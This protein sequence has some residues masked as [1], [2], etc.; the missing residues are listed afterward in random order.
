MPPTT[1]DI[2]EKTAFY[3][4]RITLKS[5]PRSDRIG[6]D[7]PLN[8]LRNDII[9]PYE[10]GEKF[11]LE[12]ETIDPY[13]IQVIKVNATL[14][15]STSLL[16]AIKAKRTK[17]NVISLISDEWRVTEE[18]KD[19]TRDLITSLPGST[20]NTEKKQFP[21]ATTERGSWISVNPVFAGRGFP[22]NDKLCFVLI[23]LNDPFTS[24]FEHNIKPVA[25]KCGLTAIKADDILSNQPIM[26]DV[27]ALL[28]QARLVIA[29]LSYS[30]PNVFYELGIA[31][32]LGKEVIM[33]AQD[34]TEA[35]FDVQHIRY[36][37]YQYPSK[38]KE[39]ESELEGTIKQVLKNPS[40]QIRIETTRVGGTQE[41]KKAI[42]NPRLER[43]ATLTTWGRE[44]AE[45]NHTK[46]IEGDDKAG[47]YSRASGEWE[48]FERITSAIR[49]EAVKRWSLA[50]TTAKDYADTVMLTLEPEFRSKVHQLVE[51][52]DARIAAENKA[53]RLRRN[54]A[55]EA[56]EQ[57]SKSRKYAVD[58]TSFLKALMATGQ[59]SDEQANEELERM[60]RTSEIQKYRD[61]FYVLRGWS[62]Y[63][64][65]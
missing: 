20:K 18:G 10:R 12:G 61:N 15:P 43:L 29:D 46:I 39:F 58:V 37:N 41:S 62:Q 28:N 30:N 53:K 6:L 24:I 52:S 8:R 57:M 35:P 50:S 4:V 13:D 31:H 36:I 45:S 59:Y 22:P 51:K 38:A 16:P 60:I 55:K 26:E 48:V 64:F 49:T 44:W 21:P 5:D 23:P 42:Q 27:W 2:V 11:I 19:F 9:G 3:H 25:E 17:E 1:G 47:F 40:T 32:T 56:F 7:F 63:D 14:V 34:F 33:I 65:Y 54:T